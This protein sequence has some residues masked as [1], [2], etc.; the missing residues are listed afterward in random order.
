MTSGGLS[1]RVA[2]QNQGI[3]RVFMRGGGGGVI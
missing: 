1:V 3:E 2:S